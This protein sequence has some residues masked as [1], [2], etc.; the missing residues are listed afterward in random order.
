MMQVIWITTNGF[1]LEVLPGDSEDSDSEEE[2]DTYYED[3]NDEEIKK[4]IKP[5]ES[6]EKKPLIKVR[7]LAHQAQPWLSTGESMV[8]S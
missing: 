2:S 8:F 7:N 6:K 3:D 5:T 1:F 4:Q